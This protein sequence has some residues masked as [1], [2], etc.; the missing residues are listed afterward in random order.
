VS[1]RAVIGYAVASADIDADARLDIV[2]G[3]F[4]GN[5]NWH[6]NL[7]GQG[8]FSA[9]QSIATGLDG[10][11]SISVGDADGDGDIDVF[12]ASR[13]DGT[14][15]WYENND[16]MGSF[17]ALRPIAVS[18]GHVRDVSLGDLDGDGDLDALSTAWP[19]PTLPDVPT[20]AWYPNQDG[21][22]DFGAARV[23][24]W[25]WQAEQIRARDMDN[26]GDLDVVY[27]ASGA[28]G[29]FVLENIDGAATFAPAAD[30]AS[31]RYFEELD[32]G[33]LD[34]DGDLDIAAVY[35]D[36]VT[37][38]ENLGA[39]R[40]ALQPAITDVAFSASAVVVGDID[41]DGRVDLI[42]ASADTDELIYRRNRGVVGDANGD[43]QFDSKDLTHVF[44]FNEYEDAVAGNSTLTE[45]DFNGDGDFTTQ[46]LVYAFAY[47]V[48]L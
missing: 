7:D 46:D 19:A 26:D 45:G 9:P 8:S 41:R 33:D 28:E 13:F 42:H 15:A 12:S 11:E 20:V 17:G 1:D 18:A 5:I 22:S 29:I 30:I 39:L 2:T 24:S 44:Q 25:V 47:G 38:I 10:L 43:N 32:I 31:L 16:G 23:L 48:Y 14:V 36:S 34:G 35:L 40:F 6:R 27:S 3:D 21:R 4:D 37:W